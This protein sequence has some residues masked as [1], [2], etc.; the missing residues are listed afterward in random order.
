VARPGQ[1]RVI[2]IWSWPSASSAT[3]KKYRN[4]HGPKPQTK[5]DAEI[6]LN[7][8]LEFRKARI[9][10]GLNAYEASEMLGISQ[11][12][13]SYY[14]TGKD[15]PRIGFLHDVAELYGIDVQIFF[16]ISKIESD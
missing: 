2:N 7:I 15:S 12:Q 4:A 8:G 6:A 3:R 14:E 10:A 5:R 13:L 11:P 16:D 1:R 9:D